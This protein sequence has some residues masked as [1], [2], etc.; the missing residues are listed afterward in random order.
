MEVFVSI[1]PEILEAAKAMGLRASVLKPEE[2]RVDWD[3]LSPASTEALETFGL[4]GVAEPAA[5]GGL[6]R[7]VAFILA[8]LI[9]AAGS[10]IRHV[11][12]T[13]RLVSTRPDE[14]L[15]P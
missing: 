12:E 1:K 5:S 15:P 9:G 7:G 2:L 13:A 3:C 10:C 14:R 6:P 8:A 4:P 11:A